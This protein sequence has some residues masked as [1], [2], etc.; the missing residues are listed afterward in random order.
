M[1]NYYKTLGLKE[2]AS[3]KEI[4]TAY[5]RLSKEL[6]PKNND[7]QEFFK[8]EYQKVQEAYEALRNSSILATEKGARI[9]TKDNSS[10]K[11]RLKNQSNTPPKKSDIR[12][13]KKN[14]NCSIYSSFNSSRYYIL[15]FV[16]ARSFFKK[17][18][19]HSK[20]HH[21]NKERFKGNY[22]SH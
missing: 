22:R 4:Q 5:E 20:R 15:S 14:W 13:F 9:G 10:S 8:E 17:K 1:K 2:G 6:D 12:P 19:H 3:Q 7:N 16:T 18:Y 21:Q 11:P